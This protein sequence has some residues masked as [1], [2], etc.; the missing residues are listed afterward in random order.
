M[1]RRALR[2]A[3]AAAL[4]RPPGTLVHR[5]PTP[6]HGC[7]G[8][9]PYYPR[10]LSSAWERDSFQELG[11]SRKGR[12]E[13]NTI[14]ALSTAPGKS[15]IA[16]VRISGP[17]CMDVRL[18]ESLFGVSSMPGAPWNFTVFHNRCWRIK[19][20]VTL[21]PLVIMTLSDMFDLTG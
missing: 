9:K 6:F 2:A 17:A 5:P 14:F 12:D 4:S 7:L 10:G 8:S 21:Q 3:V 19:Q 18:T 20:D 16:V 15:A 13:S 1:S 11:Q